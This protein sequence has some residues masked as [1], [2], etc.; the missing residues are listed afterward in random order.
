MDSLLLFG[1]GMGHVP[2]TDFSIKSRL[3]ILEREEATFGFFTFCFLSESLDLFVART[4]L[5]AGLSITETWRI[6][7]LFFLAL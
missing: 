5:L 1:E 4:H 2:A 3:K 6:F 7:P